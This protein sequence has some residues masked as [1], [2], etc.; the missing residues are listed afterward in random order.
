[1][2]F[3]DPAH[4]KR[5][6]AIARDRMR[7]ALRRYGNFLTANV[8]DLSHRFE[9]AVA[10]IGPRLRGV[11]PPDEVL[12]ARVRAAMGHAC[13]HPHGITVW[14]DNGRI[15]LRGPVHRHESDRLLA[16]VRNVRGV[17]KVTSLLEAHEEKR[18]EPLKSRAAEAKIPG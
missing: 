16:A 15:T 1:M 7:S 8:L 13:S 14:A 5:R 9:G 17:K 12:I 2:Y 6:R 4:G 3:F 11:S 18:A 10:E